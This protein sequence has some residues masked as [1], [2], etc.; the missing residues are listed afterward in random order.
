MAV[1]QGAI[2][3]AA[4][5]EDGPA[6]FLHSSYGFLRDE[7]YTGQPGCHGPHDVQE[8]VRDKADGRLYIDHTIEWMVHAVSIFTG[9]LS[10]VRA[11]TKKNVTRVGQ[12]LQRQG[13][14]AKSSTFLL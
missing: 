4:R 13:K 7:L 9:R 11:S 5:K 12:S 10:S 6:R 1:A 14:N 3:R 2:L 8:P